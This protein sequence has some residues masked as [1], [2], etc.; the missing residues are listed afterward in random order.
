MIAKSKGLKTVAV[1]LDLRR[2]FETVDREQMTEKLE[3]CGIKNSELRFFQNYLHNRRQATKFK[4]CCSNENVI[5]IG[6]PQGTALS[7]VLF[8]IYINDIAKIPLHCKIV[9]FADDTI[10]YIHAEDINEA[11]IKLMKT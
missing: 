8:I 1:F 5:P 9:L 7:V 10:I 4:E 3:K 2:A 11:I 6:L